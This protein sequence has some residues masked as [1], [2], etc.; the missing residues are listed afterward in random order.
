MTLTEQS[1]A[2]LNSLS[3]CHS[4]SSLLPVSPL[5]FLLSQPLPTRKRQDASEP[6]FST[7]ILSDALTPEHLENAFY[8]DSLANHYS[9]SDEPSSHRHCRLCD[10]LGASSTIGLTATA[11]GVTVPV[12]APISVPVSASVDVTGGLSGVTGSVSVPVASVTATVAPLT[13]I[14]P[15]MSTGL[16]SGLVGASVT[17]GSTIGA[18]ASLSVASASLTVPAAT[19]S[20]PISVP[21]VTSVRFATVLLAISGLCQTE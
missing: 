6:G 10:N 7:V 3:Y 13:S 9:R 18:S 21:A 1:P 16:Q 2:S 12:S 20:L 15:G 5:A 11:A 17:L 4:L 19:D 8:R 14:L